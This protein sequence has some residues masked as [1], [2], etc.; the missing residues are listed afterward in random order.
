MKNNVNKICIRNLDKHY[1]AGARRTQ[2]LSDV[3][4]D[5]AP[6]EFV[7]LVG[8]SGCGKSTL[9]RT[10]GGLEEYES[11]SMD[12]NGRPVDGP[13]PDRAMVFQSYSLY[14]WLTVQENVRFCRRLHH[15]RDDTTSA[16]VERASGRADALIALMGLGH[17][18]HAYPSELSGGMQQRVAIARAL[19]VKPEVLLMDEPFG[20]LDAQ[21]REVMHDLMRFL[22]L[23]EQTTVVFVT[24]DVEEAIYLGQRVVVMAPR[25]GRIDSIFDVPFGTQRDQDLKLSPEFTDLKRRILDRIRE[26]SGMKTDLEQLQKCTGDL[27]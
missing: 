12:C 10:L 22:Y 16:D 26:T 15:H 2:A 6:G 24:H 20:A 14:P 3:N 27:A 1:G 11:G 5:I 23:R 8:A 4:L 21:T 13:G 19:M 17:V 18:R 9:L 7:T 25:P